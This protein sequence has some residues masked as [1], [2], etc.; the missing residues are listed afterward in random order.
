MPLAKRFFRLITKVMILIVIT[1]S[2]LLFCLRTNISAMYTE[3][4]EV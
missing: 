1:V 3:D 2:V 4:V